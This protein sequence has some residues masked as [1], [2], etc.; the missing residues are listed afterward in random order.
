MPNN[1]T[2]LTRAQRRDTRRR[3]EQ[4]SS[5]SYI[6]RPR[7]PAPLIHAVLILT[8]FLVALPVI[9]A[10]LVAT[11]PS[12]TF[13]GQPGRLLPGDDLLENLS[14]LG[15]TAFFRQ[16]LN[17]LFVALVVVIAKTATSLL[18]GLA[19]VYFSF[20]AK[21]FLFFFVLLT[22]LMPTEIIIVPLY[23]VISGL[24]WGEYLDG[25]DR[26]LFCQ[27][28]RCLSFPAAL[29]QHSHRVGRSGST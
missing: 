15:R 24:G 25:A 13:Y 11:M 19:F 16:M 4:A 6:G 21:W 28:D 3:H 22:L 27:R 20:P 23:N 10:L 14:A 7:L 29:Q 26:A 8:C 2:Q 12:T 17:T 5:S 1:T 9:Y 18:A